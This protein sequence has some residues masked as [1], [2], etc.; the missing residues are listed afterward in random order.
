MHLL[1]GFFANGIDFNVCRSPYLKDMVRYLV[2][3]APKGYKP[4]NYEKMGIIVLSEERSR[5]EARLH[6][7][8]DGWK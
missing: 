6:D 4:P 3:I 8:K 2:N 5:I 7:I 1:G